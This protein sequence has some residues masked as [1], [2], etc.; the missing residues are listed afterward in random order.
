MKPKPFDLTFQGPWPACGTKFPERHREADDCLLVWP[1]ADRVQRVAQALAAGA[2]CGLIGNRGTG[3]TQLAYRLSLPFSHTCY[4]RAADLFGLM[5]SWYSLTGAE[6]GHNNKMLARVPLLV[7]DEMQE[8]VES[9][10]E[11]K[12]LTNLIDKRYGS[13]LPTLLIANQTPEAFAK[14]VGPSVTDRMREGGAVL[15][16]DWQ[17]FRGR[18]A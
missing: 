4:F 10:H 14:H 12:M 13:H 1:K 7:I 2:L 11:D 9:E 16:C 6:A 17:S 3:K 15:V 5:K 8:R 18:A